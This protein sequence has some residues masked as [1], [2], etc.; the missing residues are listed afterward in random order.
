[1]NTWVYV[2]V[3]PEYKQMSSPSL[4]LTFAVAI[5]VGSALKDF[6]QAI[7]TDLVTPFLSVLLPDAQHTVQGLVVQ[8][9]PV[10]LKVGDA[11]GA[12]ATL[13]IAV[14]VVAV[15]LPYLK[16]YAPLRGGSSK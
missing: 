2:F 3:Y 13:A 9:G 15:T 11:I 1:M 10:K 4:L 12:T 14:L 16:A 8:V 6:F 5:F 7:I